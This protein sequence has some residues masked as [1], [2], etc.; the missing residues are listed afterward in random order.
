MGH[1]PL[2][3]A[4]RGWSARLVLATRAAVRMGAGKVYALSVAADTPA[5]DPLAPEVMW[6]QLTKAPFAKIWDGCDC[7]AVGVGLGTGAK[8]E[9]V[10]AAAYQSSLPLIA[11]A[12]ALNLLAKKPRLLKIFKARKAD[13][14]ITPHPAEAARLLGCSVLRCNKTE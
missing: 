6:R 2:S 9:A 5:F 3:A 13:T 8:A 10:A 14:V 4:I 1:W 7:L 12:D 11:D